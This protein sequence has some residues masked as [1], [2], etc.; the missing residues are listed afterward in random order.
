[1]NRKSLGY[2]V[3]GIGLLIGVLVMRGWLAGT[4]PVPGLPASPPQIAGTDEIGSAPTLGSG[5]TPVEAS[6]A[7]VEVASPPPTPTLA[8]PPAEI[9]PDAASSFAGAEPV[10]SGWKW[11]FPTEFEQ[12]PIILDDGGFYFI[13]K[14]HTVYALNADGSPH[15]QRK[16]ED[17]YPLRNSFTGFLPMEIFGD[18]T[19]VVK[20]EERLYAIGPDGSERWSF[21]VSIPPL[22]SDAF[23]PPAPSLI[24]AGEVYLQLDATNTL[25]V[26]SLEDGLLW[27]TTFDK[28]LREYLLSLPVVDEANG[29]VVF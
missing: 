16:I 19:I 14:D 24:H 17:I 2:L 1:M 4:I 3:F 15:L 18:G 11:T 26:F 27:K 12:G 9:A 13:T 29:Q 21:P 20:T 10:P 28:P 25:H 23:D 7:P 8:L 6:P 5:N 22:P